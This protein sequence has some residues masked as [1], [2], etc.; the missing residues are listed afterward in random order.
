MFFILQGLLDNGYVPKVVKN[1]NQIMMI[2]EKKLSLRFVEVQ[3]YL[4]CTFR[5][6]CKR[7]HCPI[8]FF[9]HK[10]IQSKYFEYKGS[11]PTLKDFFDFEDTKQDLMEKEDKI[12]KFEKNKMWDFQKELIAF[13]EQKVKIIATAMLDFFQ[14]A[15]HCQRVLY[16][17]LK[18]LKPNENWNFLHP[19]NPPIFTTATYSFQLFLRIT[20]ESNNLR[21]V[22]TPIPFQS[23]KGEIE[24]IM[25]QIWKNPENKI[26]MA[27]SSEGQKNFQYTKPD[28]YF[29]GK[30]WY[31]H[32]CFYHGHKQTECKFKTKESYKSRQKKYEDF[33]VKLQ[34]M[35]KN[36]NIEDITIM[37][38]CTWRHLKKTDKDVQHF[39]KNIY[40]NPPMSR[41][42]AREAGKCFILIYSNH[43]FEIVF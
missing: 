34:K 36:S 10:W 33:E 30:V 21:T 12:K 28:G 13:L 19:A 5:E 3:N 40:R 18:P 29:N 4:H 25:Y 8:P 43:V 6:L 16:T 20:D 15:F 31:Y 7:I 11:P 14:E 22:G 9:P 41:L 32:G 42:D 37:W 27:W 2:D 23:S 24:F 35:Q 26:Q 17:N 1:Q 38:E 39:I